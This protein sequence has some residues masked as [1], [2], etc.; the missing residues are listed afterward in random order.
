M[1]RS[2][3]LPPLTP[4]ELRRL[5]RALQSS[6]YTRAMSLERVDGFFT[7]LICGPGQVPFDEYLLPVFG[8]NAGDR[9][10]LAQ[11]KVERAVRQLLQRHW[12]AISDSLRNG[13]C[14]QPILRDDAGHATLAL[15]W[16]RG[17]MLGVGLRSDGWDALNKSDE[18]GDWVLPIYVLADQ[19][20]LAARG[21]PI[22]GS[23][24]AKLV[25]AAT[26]ATRQ[27]F[28]YFRQH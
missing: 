6:K 15:E 13:E 23:Q 26:L 21:E 10:A 24:R 3:N 5:D 4:R 16:A 11:L 19:E 9:E 12:N 25:T 7:A 8:I 2:E 27:I 20:A 18:Y 17:F 1:D 28:K 14:H 22:T